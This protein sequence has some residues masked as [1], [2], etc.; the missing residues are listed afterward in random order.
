[1]YP[2]QLR[3]LRLNVEVPMRGRVLYPAVSLVI[4]LVAVA[5]AADGDLDPH[6]GV[7]GIVSTDFAGALD[8]LSAVAMQGDGKLVAVG[9]SG[10]DFALA[11][12]NVDGTLD[13]TFGTQGKVLTD[14]PGQ[15]QDVA[16]GVAVQTDGKIV[17]AGDSAGDVVVAR[18]NADGSLDRHFGTRG[19]VSTD[20]GGDTDSGEGIALQPDGKIVVVGNTIGGVALVRYTVRGRLDRSFGAGGVVYPPT[21]L[22]FFRFDL[23]HALAIQP[24]G[25]IV[26]AGS[27]FGP[28]TCCSRT[29]FL[30]ARFNSD[31]TL[32]TGFGSNR[33][34]FGELIDRQGIVTTDFEA[35]S[36]HARDVIIQP[37]GKI[38]VAGDAGSGRNET[39]PPDFGMARYDAI[40]TLDPTFGTG[41]R[42]QTRVTST[43][44][45]SGSG[46]LGVALQNDGKIVAAGYLYESLTLFTEPSANIAVVRYES[47]GIPDAA[48]GAAGT[49]VT[50]LDP[51]TDAVASDVLVQPDGK[52][53][54]AATGGGKFSRNG[55]TGVVITGGADFVL[56]RYLNESARGAFG[57]SVPTIP[58]RV[59]A[60]DYDLGGQGVGDS[61]TTPG[62]EGGFVYRTDDVDIKTSSEGGYTIGWLAAGEWLNYTVNVQTAGTYG[63]SVRVGSALPDRTFHIEV[64]GLDVTGAI[65]V[66]YVTA[67]DQYQ[68]LSLPG[69]ALS[70]GQHTIR[71][72]MGPL[73][74]MDLQWLEFD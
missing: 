28:T 42:V 29:D 67:W 65:A 5:Q 8:S 59:E 43:A 26:V 18:Y 56:A 40:G 46:I 58:G 34:P 21:P 63:L 53:V 13:S 1:M 35:R 6:F 49:V 4:L 33:G 3:R 19:G 22:H 50:D 27:G 24:D 10:T 30:L 64:D 45:R 47:N 55:S 15:G 20:L 9:V 25:K 74:F 32:D 12:Y 36:D 37:D 57:G 48:F 52:I 38:I 31:G 70:A 44:V 16:R 60:E 68:T 66:P 54:I 62:N 61:D 17:V 14:F 2:A 72:V 51:G 69:I 73:D 23:I 41:G 39:I 71:V 11:R 7:N